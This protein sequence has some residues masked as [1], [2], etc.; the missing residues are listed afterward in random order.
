MAAVVLFGA[1]WA[2][3]SRYDLR[4]VPSPHFSKSV[5][6]TRVL[7]LNWLGD[8]PVALAATNP[9]MPEPDW[10]GLTPLPAPM[11]ATGAAPLLDQRLRAPP[12]A[13]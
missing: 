3:A 12:T 4:A 5:K 1:T 10:G 2:K 9:R 13:I 6:V 11:A 7:F 8:E